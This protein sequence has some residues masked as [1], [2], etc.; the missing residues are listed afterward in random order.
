M[1]KSRRLYKKHRHKPFE[2]NV[3]A[4]NFYADGMVVSIFGPKEENVKKRIFANCVK[5]RHGI[6]QSMALL[7]HIHED[8]RR[9]YKPWKKDKEIKLIY[10]VYDQRKWEF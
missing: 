6:P 1:T 8:G 2:E 4:D 3:N 10:A 5:R 7:I 9:E